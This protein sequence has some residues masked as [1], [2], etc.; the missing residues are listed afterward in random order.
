MTVRINKPALNLREKLAELDKPS[1]IVGEQILRSDTAEDAREALNLEE[2]LFEDFESTGIQDNAT[3]TKVTVSDS[4]VD[5]DGDI[6]LDDNNKIT[7]GTG[8]DLQIYHD[9]GN[10]FI[11]DEGTGSLYIR[12]SSQVRVETPT[13][14][15]MAIFNDNGG[16]SLRYDNSKK[17]ETTSTG[18]D[19]TGTVT[20]DGLTVDGLSNM[21]GD[22]SGGSV[23]GTTLIKGRYTT[24]HHHFNLGS[25]YSTAENVLGY[26]VESSKSTPYEFISTLSNYSAPRSALTSGED[27]NFFTAS[28]QN[29]AVG[30]PVAMSKRLKIDNNGDVFLYEDTGTSAKFHWDASA[31]SLNVGGRINY[32]Y[33]INVG[34]DGYGINSTGVAPIVMRGT[35]YRLQ[36]VN[37]S[38]MTFYTSNSE[39]MRIDS[40][41]NVGIGTLNP[42]GPLHVYGADYAYFASNV[43]G[44]T[45]YSTQAGIALGWNKSSGGGESVIAH[46]KGAGALGGL[47]FVNN[48]AGAYREDMRL[49]NSGNLLVGRTSAGRG[50]VTIEPSSSNASTHF[51]SPTSQAAT[52]ANSQVMEGVVYLDTVSSGSRITLPF[53]SQGNFNTRYLIELRWVSEEYNQSGTGGA[54]R[55]LISVR[56]LNT[57][58]ASVLE[59]S[60]NFSSVSSSGTNLY[61]DVT[62]AFTGGLNNYEGCNLYYKIIGTRLDW[63][64]IQNLALN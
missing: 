43:A 48:D 10:S 64:Q 46:N 62:N 12:G 11:T 53:T 42:R 47:V 23:G 51:Y 3:S 36:G 21:T 7:L 56:S 1:G 57:L 52:G 30:S 9:G 28:A 5:V 22:R 61:I 37:P 39:R 63:V 44:V 6:S 26:G 31:E 19:V 2:H 29:T 55:A 40:S 15:N 25:M 58:S 18:V 32:G 60:G 45:P 27:I 17:F 50:Q 13:G 38:P 41:G 33:G 34:D 14:E 4:G 49:D 24:G 59:S 20:A 35:E 8:D 16:V 54:G